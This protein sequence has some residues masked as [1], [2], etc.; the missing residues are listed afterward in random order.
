MFGRNEE[1]HQ[2]TLRGRLTRADGGHTAADDRKAG[3][4]VIGIGVVL[5]FGICLVE[6][7]NEDPVADA[8][9][10]KVV[11]VRHLIDHGLHAVTGHANA[12]R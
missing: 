3:W 12:G 6:A 9:H 8:D 10:S 5:L 7:E 11:Q 2:R 4:I 1:A